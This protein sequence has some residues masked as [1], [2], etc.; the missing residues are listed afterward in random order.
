MKFNLK[1]K[2]VPVIMGVYTALFVS[3]RR[4][5][6][7]TPLAPNEIEMAVRFFFIVFSDC[8]CWMPF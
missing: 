5:K 6:T 1:K 2:S 3:I 8:L 4:T 7:A